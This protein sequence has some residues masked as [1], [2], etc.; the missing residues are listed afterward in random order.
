MDTNKII[1]IGIILILAIFLLTTISGGDQMGLLEFVMIA[2]L[3]LLFVMF[4]MQYYNGVDITASLSKLFKPE[5]DIIV[6]SEEK[7]EKEI[8]TRK[9]TYHVNGQF[10]YNS[11]KNICRAYG[12]QLASIQNLN[13][14][15]NKGGEW[16]EYGWSD[17]GM[18][19]YPTQYSTWQK[20]KESGRA[21]ECG[22]PGVNGG[23]I[24][25]PSKKLGVNCYGLK[26]PPPKGFK[27]MVFPAPV[28][29]TDLTTTNAIA[30]FN[31][32]NW[33]D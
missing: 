30:P 3:I 8:E 18:A 4:G 7:V 27:P 33:N 16:C 17:D 24:N 10:N 25:N 19:L 5:L 13:D 1:I 14:T 23:Y 20:L 11:A 15:Y 28:S 9:E 22:R 32:K 31:Y 2:A 26:P 6:K 12:G 29:T 21:E